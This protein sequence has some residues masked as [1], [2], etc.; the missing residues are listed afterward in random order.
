M[1][2]SGGK[3]IQFIALDDTSVYWTDFALGT[4]NAVPK[5]GGSV[6]VLAAGQGSPSGLVVSHGNVYWTEFSSDAVA[7]TATSGGSA[8]SVATSQDGAY[9]ITAAGDAVYWTTLRVCSVARSESGGKYQVI[10]KAKQP[11]TAI[12]STPALVFWV[13]FQRK[14][15]ERYDIASS[16]TSILLDANEIDLP[17][18][19]ATDGKSVYFAGPSPT[20]ID[21][22]AIPIDGGSAHSLHASACSVDAGVTTAC[23]GGVATDGAFVYFTAAA[24]DG[25]VVRKVPVDGGDA[26]TIAQGQAR[27]FAVAVDDACVYWSNLADGTV[28]AAPKK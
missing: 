17:S 22:G 1:L 6:S 15:I 18:A 10:E 7:S 24:D 12:T 26:T 11:F 14:A 13:S 21:I 19:L 27:P 4:V 2:A 23:A 16:T 3:Q 5:G 8:T 20:Q 28:W 9:E 25:G